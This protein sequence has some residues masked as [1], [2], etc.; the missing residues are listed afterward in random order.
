VG[1]SVDRFALHFFS[2]RLLEIKI[3]LMREIKELVANYSKSFAALK[4]SASS[5]LIELPLAKV[6]SWF[7]LIF[8]SHIPN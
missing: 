8:E 5:N 4:L 6:D 7:L 3:I 1:L 2:H